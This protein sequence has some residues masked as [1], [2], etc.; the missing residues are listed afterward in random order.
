MTAKKLV[1]NK[2]KIVEAKEL[3]LDVFSMALEARLHGGD[4]EETA[5]KITPD[6]VVRFAEKVADTALDVV[7]GR[8][9][10]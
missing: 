3:W 6:E 9:P 4:I 7:E 1:I 8:W 10:E 2:R 5:I